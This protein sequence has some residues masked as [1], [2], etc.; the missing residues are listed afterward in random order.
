[1]IHMIHMIPMIPMIPINPIVAS[2]MT[3]HWPAPAKPA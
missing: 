1:M 3:N 2:K